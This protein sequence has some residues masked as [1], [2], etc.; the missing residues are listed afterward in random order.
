M[1]FF[2]NFHVEKYDWLSWWDGTV[3]PV[4][5]LDSA[6]LPY[7]TGFRGYFIALFISH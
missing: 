1:T 2:F 5:N 7:M 3:G 6:N 4:D